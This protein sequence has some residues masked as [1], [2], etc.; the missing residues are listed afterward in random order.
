M[1]QSK[2]AFSE[3]PEVHHVDFDSFL[4]SVLS[5]RIQEGIAS[6]FLYK[7]NKTYLL[8][9]H[10]IFKGIDK[11]KIDNDFIII[12]FGFRTD[13]YINELKTGNLSKEQYKGIEFYN[14]PG[15]RIVNNAL[16][17]L[18]KRDLPNISTKP[19]SNNIIEKYSL[20]KISEDLESI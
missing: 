17:V 3:N 11:L 16:F 4:A 1:L 8:K 12:G 7:R 6:T 20:E 14:Y 13:F 15:S 18:S 5:K 2:D 19:I 10:D 9:P